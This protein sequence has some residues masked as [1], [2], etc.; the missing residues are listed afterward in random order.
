MPVEKYQ[1][2]KLIKEIIGGILLLLGYKMEHR[3]LAWDYMEC[4]GICSP[5]QARPSDER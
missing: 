5:F 2:G 3:N 1:K 4:Q